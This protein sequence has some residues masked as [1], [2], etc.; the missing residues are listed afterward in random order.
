MSIILPNGSRV[1]PMT[2]EGFDEIARC[3]RECIPIVTISEALDG[4]RTESV[5]WH[6][7]DPVVWEVPRGYQG[8][9]TGKYYFERIGGFPHRVFVRVYRKV[10]GRDRK[11]WWRYLD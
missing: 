6:P 9:R 10:Y 3:V 1:S 5:L 4:S 7:D 2:K 8:P 11:D